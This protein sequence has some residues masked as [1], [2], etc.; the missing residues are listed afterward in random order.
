MF[1]SSQGL[2]FFLQIVNSLVV[3]S[4]LVHDEQMS[5]IIVK[6]VEENVTIWT[7]KIVLWELVR[8]VVVNE[9]L[10]LFCLVFGV[11]G[12]VNHFWDG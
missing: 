8:E 9:L 10:F 5:M 2:H 6:R 1:E 12:S 11:S 7:V 4:Y 3:F